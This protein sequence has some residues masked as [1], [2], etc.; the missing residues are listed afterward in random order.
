MK[1]KMKDSRAM[2]IRVKANDERERKKAEREK[3]VDAEKRCST[4]TIIASR[5][6]ALF[7]SRHCFPCHPR[8]AAEIYALGDDRALSTLCVCYVCVYV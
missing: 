8:A 1:K 4:T 3:S 6:V 5:A 2:K 7:F